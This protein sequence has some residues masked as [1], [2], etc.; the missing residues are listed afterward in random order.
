MYKY[1]LNYVV[2]ISMMLPSISNTTPLYL[3]GCFFSWTHCMYQNLDSFDAKLLLELKN[4]PF[5]FWAWVTVVNTS[6]CVQLFSR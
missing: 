5:S 3:G 6:K 4:G 2:K 1:V